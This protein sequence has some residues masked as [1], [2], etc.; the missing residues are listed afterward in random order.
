MF[1]I[2]LCIIV[3]NE[4]NVL[5]RC[6]ECGKAFADEIVIVDT[7]SVDRTKEIAGRYT[8]LIYDFPWGDDFSAARN[9]AFSKGSCDYLMWMDADDVMSEKEIAKLKEL[10]ETKA[11]DADMIMMK[12]AV[13]FHP[14]GSCSFSYYRERLVKRQKNFRFQ[15][16]VHEAI[17]PAGKISWEEIVIEHRKETA[18]EAGRNLRIYRMMEQKKEIFSSRDLYYYGRELLY[19]GENSEAVHIFEKFFAEKN[20]WKENCIDA[21]RQMAVCYYRLGEPQKALEALF[22]SFSYDTPRGEICCDIG[23]HFLDRGCFLQASYWLKQALQAAPRENTGA[24]VEKDCY[25]YL[26]AIWLCVC[27]DRLGDRKQARYY[28][29]LAGRYHPEDIFYLKNRELLKKEVAE[30]PLSQ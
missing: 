21:C 23:K 8:T 3:K 30:Q 22:R 28:N 14:D 18:G 12:Y 25:G 19:A 9:F 4:E 10:K 5:A 24:F 11:A 1:T 26:P 17:V 13:G 29:E 2:S 16:R 6:L 7:G 27:Y 20:G 15:G